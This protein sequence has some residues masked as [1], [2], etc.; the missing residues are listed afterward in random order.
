MTE[1]KNRLHRARCV[2]VHFLTCPTFN[3][4]EPEKVR[5]DARKRGCRYSFPPGRFRGGPHSFP[6]LPAIGLF[7]Q[8]RASLFP[9]TCGRNSSFCLE[10]PSL[11]QCRSLLAFAT[12]RALQGLKLSP[13]L[14]LNEFQGLCPALREFP[15]GPTDGR[16]GSPASVLG[17]ALRGVP[18]ERAAAAACLSWFRSSRDHLSKLGVRGAV[19]GLLVFPFF[20]SGKTGKVSGS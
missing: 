4:T 2:A 8:L 5:L 11:R 1:K 12:H 15:V 20:P 3:F 13:T 14:G 16:S 7:P 18:A 9:A 17:L 10:P 19:A 6:F